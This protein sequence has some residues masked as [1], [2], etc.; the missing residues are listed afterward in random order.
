MDNEKYYELNNLNFNDIKYIAKNMY[1][2]S[3]RSKKEY[4]N[5]IIDAFQEYEDYKRC[6]IDKYKKINT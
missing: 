3:R 1:L 2:P 5:D 6:K 4:I